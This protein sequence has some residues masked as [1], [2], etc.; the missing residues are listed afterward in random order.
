MRKKPCFNKKRYFTYEAKTKEKLSN[1]CI[2]EQFELRRLTFDMSK[3][4]Y[5][6]FCT[7]RKTCKYEEG[8][9]VGICDDFLEDSDIATGILFYKPV[10]RKTS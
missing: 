4:S 8:K 6:F 7:E 9:F 10:E 5:C 1:G 2:V 3:L